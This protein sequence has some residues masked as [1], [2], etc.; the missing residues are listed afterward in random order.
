M[1]WLLLLPRDQLQPA[2][3]SSAAQK[4]QDTAVANASVKP[5]GYV[6]HTVFECLCAS[7]TETAACAAISVS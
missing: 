4:Q 3:L 7:C 5:F 1:P 2:V 6:E